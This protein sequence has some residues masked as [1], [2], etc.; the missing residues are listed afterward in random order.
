MYIQIFPSL[1]V[2]FFISDFYVMNLRHQGQNALW[3]GEL[4]DRN[5]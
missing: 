2:Q 5:K 3:K 1:E 4:N